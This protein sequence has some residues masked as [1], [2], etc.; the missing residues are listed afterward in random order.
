MTKFDVVIGNPPYMRNLHL[1][2]LD[3]AIDISKEY[4]CFIHPSMWLL[5]GHITNKKMISVIKEKMSPYKLNFYLINGYYYFWIKTKAQFDQHLCI[6]C[7][8]KLKPKQIIVKNLITQETI[9]YN[10]FNEIS[11]YG[12]SPEYISLKNKILD[13]AKIVNLS[14]KI[15]DIPKYK[16]IINIPFGRGTYYYHSSDTFYCEDFFTFFTKNTTILNE[17]LLAFALSFDSKYNAENCLNY[18]KTDFARF[19]LSIKYNKRHVLKSFK[20]VPWLDFN[21]HWTD[22]KLYEYFQLTKDEIAFIEKNIPKYY[23]KI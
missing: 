13:K 16:H 11:Y 5:D 8:D 1:K 17:K 10:N 21:Q 22:E 20:T 14:E 18:L 7:I 12:K 3:I 4:V 9:E 6:S 19:A 2:F 23:A 15:E